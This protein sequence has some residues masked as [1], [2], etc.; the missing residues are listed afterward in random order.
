MPYGDLQATIWIAGLRKQRGKGERAK[1]SPDQGTY[2]GSVESVRKTI[3]TTCRFSGKNQGMWASPH[4]ETTRS[5]MESGRTDLPYGDLQA[6]IWIAGLRKQRGK[7]ERAKRVRP[8]GHIPVPW[9]AWEGDKKT[10]RFSV[11]RLRECGYHRTGMQPYR[12]SSVGGRKF[13]IRSMQATTWIAGL[14]GP[15]FTGLMQD[16]SRLGSRGAVL[17]AVGAMALVLLLRKRWQDAALL[18]LAYGGGADDGIIGEVILP[19]TR[20]PHPW[21]WS[22][23]T[24]FPAAMPLILC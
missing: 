23:A 24:V 10:C 22:T 19:E 5:S 4:L 12:Q 1:G 6:T 18:V 15:G 20:P 17:A 9:R 21:S 11:N 16:I 3:K 8:Q 13:A 2:T 7:G 14:I